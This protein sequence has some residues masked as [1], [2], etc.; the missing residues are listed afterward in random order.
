MEINFNEE[1]VIICFDGLQITIQKD[2]AIELSDRIFDYFEWGDS[3][4]LT[5]ND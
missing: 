1:E 2:K 5:K 4:E 3:K